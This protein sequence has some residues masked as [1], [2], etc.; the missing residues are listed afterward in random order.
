MQNRFAHLAIAVFL[1]C[2]AG[3][4]AQGSSVPAPVP[5]AQPA[6]APASPEKAPRRMLFSMEKGTFSGYSDDEMVVLK[7]SFLT[8]LAD[9]EG[10]PVPIDYGS[11]GFPGSQNDRN[12]AARDAGAD[13]WLVL[14][15][16][17]F[18]GSPSI[19]VLSYDL[20]YNIK[21]LDFS[22]SH[23]EAFSMLDIFRERWDDVVRPIVKKYPPLVSHAYSRGPPA[24]VTLTIHG[25]PGTEIT[26]LPSGRLVIGS[27]GSASVDLPSPAPYSFRA[28]AAGY[29][30]S[31]TRMYLDGQ[32][33][34]TLDQARS[35]WLRLDAAFLD[36]FFPGASA[37]FSI[38]SLPLFARVGFTTF[39]VG[40]AVNNKDQVLASIPLSQVTFHLGFYVSPEDRSTRLYVGAGALL[41]ISLP[42]G[43]QTFTV[44]KLLPWGV[45]AIA[46]V[47]FPVSG[48]LR[49]FVEYSPSF[50]FTPD[51]DL[52]KVSFGKDSGT[53]PYITVPPTGAI[54]LFE[55]RLGFRW[56]L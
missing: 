12:K 22:V 53:F 48:K 56:V 35:P 1:L 20:L 11:R 44:D 14:K 15:I 38:P 28:A 29:V 31:T 6:P 50:Y 26:G 51:P 33:E 16:G 42:P 25:A 21:S 54:D 3:A 7:R 40:I 32:T 37:N 5:S 2:A 45:Q 8:A 34:I 13:C 52:F 55:A 19:S 47:E 24:P 41:R 17:G 18:R 23:P 30:P 27:D 9:A 4:G 39:R 10:A 49:A 36:G 46:G 43:S